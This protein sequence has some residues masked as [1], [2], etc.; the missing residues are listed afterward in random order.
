MQQK[1]SNESVVLSEFIDNFGDY[2]ERYSVAS[3]L[4][5]RGALREFASILSG[6]CI[7]EIKFIRGIL[8][9]NVVTIKEAFYVE[10][11]HNLFKLI[12]EKYRGAGAYFDQCETLEIIEEI[13]SDLAILGYMSA[14]SHL[15]KTLE[16]H[17]GHGV[18][19]DSKGELYYCT[20]LLKR[21]E[22]LYTEKGK[23]FATRKFLIEKNIAVE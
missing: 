12:E 5:K 1:R 18:A 6:V 22:T 8:K 4:L 15:V 3:T 11:S 20:K 10:D 9:L 19:C 23:E 7:N 14:L 13:C 16:Y 2:A 21:I 17:Q